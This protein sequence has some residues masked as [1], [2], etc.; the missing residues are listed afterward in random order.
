MATKEQGLI[1][2]AIQNIRAL[3]LQMADET[4]I[5]EVEDQVSKA[6]EDQWIT[7]ETAGVSKN[8]YYGSVKMLMDQLGQEANKNYNKFRK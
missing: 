3:C 6:V 2:I 8:A 4:N 1:T 7:L 5:E